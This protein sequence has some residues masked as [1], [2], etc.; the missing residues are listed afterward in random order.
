MWMLWKLFKTRCFSTAPK[1][2]AFVE[3]HAAAEKWSGRG[4]ERECLQMMGHNDR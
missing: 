4:D 1:S 2:L 3:A